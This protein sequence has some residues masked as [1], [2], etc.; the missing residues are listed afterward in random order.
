MLNTKD[1]ANVV[2]ESVSL[3][4]VILAYIVY[5]VLFSYHSTLQTT[6]G[7]LVFGCD[8][9]LDIYSQPNYKDMWLRIQKLIIY[10]N[11]RE[12]ANQVQHDYE[13]GHYTYITRGVNYRIL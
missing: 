13:V 3:W 9:I 7:K 11:K 5:A 4:I 2:F 6:P 8:M 12:N 1:E 10:N